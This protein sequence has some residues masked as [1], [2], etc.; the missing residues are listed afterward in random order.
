MYGQG[1]PEFER[2]VDLVAIV[3]VLVG[4]LGRE[5]DIEMI[6][7]SVSAT[8]TDHYADLTVRDVV[9]AAR[10]PGPSRSQLIADLDHLVG[11]Y[12]VLIAK[13][14]DTAS[15]CSTTARDQS[16]AEL[17]LDDSVQVVGTKKL[18]SG[19]GE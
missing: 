15:P 11:V 18:P 14:P 6:A 16:A 8:C 13:W 1:V 7:A 12:D 17:S 10:V 19:S 5:G 2:G 4:L 3:A 9:E